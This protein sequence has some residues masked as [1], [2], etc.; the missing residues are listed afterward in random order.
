MDATT[1]A[2]RLHRGR[3]GIRQAMAQWN[4]ADLEAVEE[5]RRLLAAAVEDMRA[6]ESAARNG[7]VTPTDGLRT[8]LLAAQRE[9]VQATRVVDACVA[10][11]RGLAARM[12]AATPGYDA[13]G[14]AAC[15]TAGLEHDV[16]G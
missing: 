12:G 13:A 16:H 8:T 3:A 9:I 2:Q 14:H 11:H 10:F 4:A 15:E 5:S 7:G 6:F 1:A